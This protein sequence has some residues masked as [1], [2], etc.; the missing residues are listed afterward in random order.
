MR[1]D[2]P[3]LGAMI[4]SR[5]HALSNADIPKL[6]SLVRIPAPVGCN[7]QIKDKTKAGDKWK[8]ESLPKIEATSPIS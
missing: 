8:G 4:T 2:P 3:A 6:P 5:C 7:G 1:G